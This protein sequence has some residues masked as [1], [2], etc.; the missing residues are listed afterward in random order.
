MC[1]RLIPQSLTYIETYIYTYW[2]TVVENRVTHMQVRSNTIHI[3]LLFLRLWHTHTHTHTDR[4]RVTHARTHHT[5]THSPTV[6]QAVT[7]TQSR[8]QRTHTHTHLLSLRLWHSHARTHSPTVSGCDTDTQSRTHARTHSPTVSGCGTSTHI[9]QQVLLSVPLLIVSLS[10]L[11]H[12]G[13]KVLLWSWWVCWSRCFLWIC[14]Y[15]S[16]GESASRSRSLLSHSEHTL[17]ALWVTSS[18]CVCPSRW[19]VCVHWA[20]TWSGSVSAL[21]LWH[22]GDNLP[23]HN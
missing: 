8:T 12:N 14:I 22:S 3:R 5:H 4:Y 13:C 20:C 11:F 17:F 7:Q 16:E 10:D 23:V 1:E 19:L 18:F 6:Y 2:I 15:D 9:S 21:C